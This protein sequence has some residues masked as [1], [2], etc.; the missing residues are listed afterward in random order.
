MFQTL[1]RVMKTPSDTLKVEC[2]ACH[3]TA[4]WE[5]AQAFKL[6]GSDASPYEVRT[7]LRCKGCGSTRAKVWI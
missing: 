6:F 2:A 4:N 5:R 1:A 3:R 7:R